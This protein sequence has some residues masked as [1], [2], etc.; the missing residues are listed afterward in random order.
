MFLEGRPPVNLGVT[1]N[2]DVFGGTQI[3][4]GDVLG[5]KQFNLFAVVDRAVPH[6]VARAT[7]TSSR[8]FQFALQGFSQTQFF[9][10]A[11]E[12][13]FYDPSLAP[14][15]S[16]DQAVATRTVRGGSAFGIYPFNRYRRLELSAGFYHLNE[17]YNDPVL[18]DYLELLQEL[19]PAAV[20]SATARSC[21]SASRSSRRRRSSASSGRWPAARCASR[22]DVAP[23]IGGTLSRQTF[24]VDAR[25]YQR[26][27]SSGV[28]ALRFR[29]FKSIGE[30]PDYI[31]FGGNSEMRGY[32]YLQFVGQNVV[33][34]NAELRFPIIEAALTPIGVIGG[35]RGVFF[36]NIGGGWFNNQG[37][38]FATDQPRAVHAD[39]R[40]PAAMPAARRSSTSRPACR[41]RSTG[42]SRSVRVP[43]E[44]RPRLVRHRARDLRARLPDSLR[45]G[46]ADAVQR[47]VGGRRSSRP[48]AAATSS[49]S[50]VRGLDRLRLLESTRRARRGCR[51][52]GS[53]LQPR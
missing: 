45:L 48:T 41:S 27:A 47:A 2:G 30:Y 37:F 46:V 1:S 36:A 29:G 19:Q 39:H 34:A 16:R 50:R 11:L 14:L 5:D 32:D 51:A 10:G 24:D 4:F 21:R 9:Y 35:I 31:Y 53:R 12:G 22:Y 13:V 43:A 8:R 20:C 40:L 52:E 15:I 7:S 44:G 25:Y 33:F 28:L 49:A 18:Q 23:K 3:S 26:L 38:K 17:E 42:R 6:A